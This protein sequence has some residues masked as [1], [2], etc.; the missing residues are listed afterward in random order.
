MTEFDIQI[1]PSTQQPIGDKNKNGQLRLENTKPNFST[2]RLV[3]ICQ[4]GHSS[5][6]N[7]NSENAIRTS[8]EKSKGYIHEITSP[9]NSET[10]KRRNSWKVEEKRYNTPTNISEIEELEHLKDLYKRSKCEATTLIGIQHYIAE[11]AMVIYVELIK[12]VLITMISSAKIFI[13]R[14]LFRFCICSVCNIFIT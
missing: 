10:R 1:V 11:I 5:T 12:R 6:Q 8:D 14:T 9:L 2:K 4:E 7:D 13:D 3:H